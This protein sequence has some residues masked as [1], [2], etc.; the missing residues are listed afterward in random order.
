[1]AAATK[2]RPRKKATTKIDPV[3]AEVIRGALETIAF[4]MAT[5][6]SLT[7][8][9]P[10]LNQSNERN[11]TILDEDGRLAA[12]D[13]GVPQFMLSS[14][15]PI[16]F[17]L[18]FFGRDGLSD[19]DVIA[20]NDP[21][22]GGGHLP[23]WSIFAP[24]FSKGELVLF[25]SIQC[26]HA[27][28]AGM[29]PGGYP[30][31]AMD[32]WAEG[33]RC[34]AVKLVEGGRERKDV[35]YLFQTNN[36]TP[37]YSGD[38]R[39]QVGAA[40]L[41][42]R[43]IRELCEKHGNETIRAAVDYTID[44]SERRFR[45]EISRWPDGEYEADSFFDHDVKGN[46]DV[47][48]HCM[49]TVKGNELHIDF[50]GSDDRGFLQCWSTRGN[51]RSM[52]MAQLC[53]M[54]PSEIPKNEGLFKPL[55]IV[56]PE[57]TIVNPEMGKPVSMGTHHPGCEI[58]EA[59]ALALSQAIPERSVP[60]VYKAAMPTVMFGFNPK[61]GGLFIDHSVDTTSTTSSAAFGQDG[62]GCTN[63]GFG[64]LVM[65]T[66]EVNESIFPHRQLSHALMTDT[67]G[68]GQ[69][70]GQ[71]GSFYIKEVT[72]P[73]MV[74]TFVLGMKYPAVGINGGRNGSP[75]HLGIRRMN[76]ELEEIKHTA[77]YVPL[78]PGERIEYRFAG[79]GGWGDPLERHPERVL[80][81]VLDEYVSQEAAE[82]DYGVI[83]TGEL[84]DY[85]L[86]VDHE[87]THRRRE[88]LRAERE[89]ASGN[90]EDS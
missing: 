22:H 83:L 88:E 45:E 51:T 74:Y 32:I 7:A 23:D 89:R 86:E 4:E 64:N 68:P 72:L 54:I 39:A 10:I 41:G 38:L 53:S 56:Y 47:K 60:Q 20:C 27:D 65:A 61:T 44:L 63:A 12:L 69:W 21:Y 1:M 29:M 33:F 80:D 85:S 2:T 42:A 77:L 55:S 57:N 76:G 16:R 52:T 28:T 62:W 49:V 11:A 58:S 75:N 17:A 48:V 5:H 78:N 8:T 46:K 40:Q 34:P 9:T 13:V 87:A 19:G 14:M 71:C 24:V 3:T 82:H 25:A 31:D 90:G 70:R 84:V 36:R 50:T 35:F 37:T 30:A 81:D 79:G 15:G 67:G 73:Q 26:H 6:V 43:R 18:E 59:V 66:A